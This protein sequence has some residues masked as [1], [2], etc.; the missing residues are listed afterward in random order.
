MISGS[1]APGFIG[2]NG[3]TLSGAPVIDSYNASQ[4]AYSS[5]SA[6]HNSVV[7]SNSSISLAG[8]SVIDG[9][10]NPGKGSSVTLGGTSSVTGS[11]TPLTSTLTLQRYFCSRRG[12]ALADEYCIRHGGLDDTGSDSVVGR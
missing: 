11:T 6:T 3:V 5:G 2:L 8:S 10:A 12:C 7:E 9:N 4:G 1:T